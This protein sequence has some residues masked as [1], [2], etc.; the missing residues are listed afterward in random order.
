MGAT[1]KSRSA[2]FSKGTFQLR[3][4]QSSYNAIFGYENR[5]IALKKG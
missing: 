3:E 4:V 5:D 2:R 1:E